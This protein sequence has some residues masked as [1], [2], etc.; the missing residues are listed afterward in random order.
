MKSSN[1]ACDVDSPEEAFNMDDL[2]DDANVDV[3]TEDDDNIDVE[4]EDD[5][6]FVDFVQ[7]DGA[8]DNDQGIIFT[9]RDL[10]R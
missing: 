2:E 7:V 8:A 1:D 4:T 6:H 9:S 3:E 10:W 5:I